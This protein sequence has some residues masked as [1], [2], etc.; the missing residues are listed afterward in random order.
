MANASFIT[1]RTLIDK[2]NSTMVIVTSVAAFVLVFSLVSTKTLI[3]Q[4]TYQNRVIS[5]KKAALKQLKDDNDAIKPLKASYDSFV[6]TAQNK[7]GGNPQGTG[8]KDGDNAKIVLDAL[9]SSYDFPALAT[10]IE[11][12]VT[13]QGLQ[14]GSIGGT[15]DEVNQAG[16]QISS[17]PQPVP[18]PFQLTVTGGYSSIQNL[19]NAFQYSIRPFQVQTMEITGDQDKLTLTLN[20]QTFFQPAKSLNITTEVIK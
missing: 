15:D 2:A 1:K 4:A 8:P 11:S 3:S 16:N 13:G 18:M 9:P 12:L 10:S 14:I 20:A 6:S 7:I 19:M 17:T 5:A